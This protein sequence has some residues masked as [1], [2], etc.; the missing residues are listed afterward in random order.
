MALC[1]AA[2]LVALT[3]HPSGSSAIVGPF[4]P[5]SVSSASLTDYGARCDGTTNDQPALQ[6]AID[7][8]TAKGGGA[9]DVRG[10]C[11]IVQSGSAAVTTLTGPVTIRGMSDNATLSLDTDQPGA[12]RKLFE[13]TGDDV[14]LQDVTLARTADVYGIMIDLHG[15]ANFTMDGVVLDGYKDAY[16]TSV[17]HGIAISG[18]SGDLTDASIVDSTIRYTDFGLFQD[19]GVTTTTDGFSVDRSTFTENRADDLEFNSPNGRMVNIAV[20][21]SHFS[22]NRASDDA[23]P[24]GFGV[25]LA[26]VQHAMIHNNTFDGYRYAPVHIE[27]RSAD[28]TVDNNTFRNSFTAALNFASHVFVVSASRDITV[29]DNLFD[30]SSNSNTINCVYLGSGGGGEVSDIRV[31][32]NTF[33]LRPSAT[34]IGQ[35]GATNVEI[36]GNTTTTLQ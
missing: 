3:I 7:D 6:R 26:N 14:T 30:T 36:S 18:G 12:F 22:H 13:V 29:T 32:S 24:A 20:T 5:A 19:S 9:I 35:Y 2:V 8:M 31:A 25:G 16:P 28:I 15:P 17:F 33:K 11:R 21:N 34:E 10:N 4:L 27:D 1:A 23:A